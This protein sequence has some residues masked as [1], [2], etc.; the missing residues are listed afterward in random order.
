MQYP[1]IVKLVLEKGIDNVTVPEQIKFE[2]LTEAGKLLLKENRYEEAGKALYKAGNNEE[3]ILLGDWLSQRERHKEASYF[4]RHCN[5][6]EKIDTCGMDC[7]NLGYYR[8]A[9]DL[10]GASSNF[11]MITFLKENF[12]V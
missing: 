11:Q 3:L 9:K 8:E 1:A 2:A 5:N 12:G 6:K 7:M 10:F 4:Y